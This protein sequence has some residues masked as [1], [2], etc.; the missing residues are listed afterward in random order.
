MLPTLGADPISDKPPGSRL[1]KPTQ[2]VLAPVFAS[3]P[4]GAQ[5]AQAVL[6]L[7]VQFSFS[8]AF[9]VGTLRCGPHGAKRDLRRLWR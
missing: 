5:W 7:C 6:C 1:R 9:W 8:Q 2:N 4:A 3:L